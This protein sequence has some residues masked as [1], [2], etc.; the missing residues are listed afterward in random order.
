MPKRISFRNLEAF[1]TVAHSPSI[2]RA[3]EILNVAQPALSQQ[4]QSLE[5]RLGIPL[6]E[7]NA[8]PFQLT[9][10]G[11]LLEAGAEHLLTAFDD[12]V[13]QLRDV[14]A[15]RRGWLGVGFTRSAMYA[16]LPPMIRAFSDAN[17][18]VDLKLYAMLTEEQPE[19][20]RSGVIH[21][22]LA[23]DPPAL[24][25]INQEVLLREEIVVALPQHHPLAGEDLVHI[26][27]LADQPFILFP[28]HPN[29]TFPARISALCREAGFAPN[30]ARQACEIQSALGLVAA[31]LGVT[32]VAASVATHGRSDLRFRALDGLRPGTVTE[33]VALTLDRA[34]HPLTEAMLTLMRPTAAE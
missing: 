2:S 7:R 23:R 33:L 25:Q 10:A 17:P 3:A 27:R 29:A 32:L 16:F 34:K 26:R 12:L 28:K 11:R 20:L 5:T 8:R 19:A 9:E 30:V 21:L 24:P 31:G 18:N 14:A 4:L 13:A 1:L 15:G 22:G 6:L